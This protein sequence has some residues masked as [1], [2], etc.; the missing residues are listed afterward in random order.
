M[1]NRT[2]FTWLGFASAMTISS[3]ANAGSLAPLT[4]N[5]KHLVTPT[6]EVVTL[7]GV[8][9][10]NWLLLEPWMWGL[11]QSHAADGFADQATIFEVLDERFGESR[12]DEL[13][14]IYRENWMTPR[15]FE[16]IKSFGFNVVRLPFHYSILEDPDN[17]GQ[18]RED[19]FKWIDRGI[20]MS[21]DAGMYVI[22]DLHGVPGGQ[23]I[24]AP[25][26]QVDQNKLWD[27]ADYQ[28]RTVALWAALAK[29]YAG[30]PV[31]AAYDVVNEPFG[32]FQVNISPVMKDLFGRLHD[33]IR[34]F[35]AD[36]LIYAPGT[37][38]GIAFYGDP[39]DQGWTNVGFTEHTYPGLFGWGEA[40]LAGH[41][42]FLTQWIGGKARMIDSMDVPYFVGEFNVVFDHVG[43][44]QLMRTYFDTYNAQGWAATM[45][46]Y[47]I[48]KAS[49][50]IEDSNWYMVT[51]A[52]SFDMTDLRTVDDQTLE[53]RFRSLGHMPLAID[54]DLRGALTD[55]EA[56]AMALPK[57]DAVFEAPD[58]TASGWTAT[59]I[60]GATPGGLELLA[61]GRWRVSGGGIDV[62]NDHDDFRLVHQDASKNSKLWTRLDA[63]GVTDRYAKAGL[64]LR[65]T[66]D[67][68]SP[69][70]LLHALPDGRVVFAERRTRG[71]N[72]AEQTLAISGFPVGLG[73][74]RDGDEL[75]LHFTGS[76]G[77]WQSTRV[78]GTGFTDGLIGLAVLAH[79]E[80]ALCEAVFAT[81]STTTPTSAIQLNTKAA[82]D[83]L[84]LNASFET[85][86]DATTDA[87]QAKNWNRWGQW[88]N[89]Q[90]GWSPVRSGNSIQAYHHW[91]ISS[92]DNSGIWQDLSGLARGTT[93]EFEVYA[94]LDAGQA[95]KAAPGS[96][97]LRLEAPQADGSV[98]TLASSSY[99]AK[100]IATGD[101]W[102]RLTL[103]GEATGG[104]ARVLLIVYPAEEGPRDGALKFDDASLRALETSGPVEPE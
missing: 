59:D 58:Q 96:V 45:W 11:Q 1:F 28:D 53:A 35:D 84:L 6:G 18:L 36:T 37:L 5:G 72:T 68:D 52:E 102:S 29:R 85:V 101:G 54:D 32:D 94:N 92:G 80:A 27:S 76:D 62:F 23:S 47:K 30:H 57:V 70:A 69:H 7:R 100:D 95:G 49:P 81:P 75:V 73:M 87:D 12:A 55:Y 104:S 19:A 99:P 46:S 67:V 4:V 88:L 74:E 51:N 21:Q 31:V 33:T 60:G 65:E 98:L 43:G 77:Q 8:N 22:L 9:T 97:E 71:G 82:S 41:A 26:G 90:E 42:R 2:F 61:D 78:P 64:M 79:D 24:D 91:E 17:P 86:Q 13:M 39:A 50:G 66:T 63:M 40:S 20:E 83:N 44:A 14:D 3:F 56:A 103:T 48:T 34:E 93:Y 10:G 25:T 89:R 16:I 38:Q 15:D